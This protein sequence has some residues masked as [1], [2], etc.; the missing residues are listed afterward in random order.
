MKHQTAAHFSAKESALL[1]ALERAKELTQMYLAAYSP[2]YLN[3]PFAWDFNLLHDLEYRLE[4]RI[5]DIRSD[6][7]AWHFDTFGWSV[8]Y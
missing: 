5:K 2:L 1:A 6:F 7:S 8:V 3:W 4:C